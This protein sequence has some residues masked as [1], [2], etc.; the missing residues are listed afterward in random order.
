ME[1]ENME[2]HMTMSKLEIEENQ[3]KKR[4]IAN[5]LILMGLSYT[6]RNDRVEVGGMSM[7]LD[8]AVQWCIGA[9]HRQ[10]MEKV[11]KELEVA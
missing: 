6:M 2:S 11:K 9:Y 3:N 7:L 8:D 5:L 1:S 10:T 4:E